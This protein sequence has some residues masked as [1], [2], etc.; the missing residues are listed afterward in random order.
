MSNSVFAI[1]SDGKTMDPSY[2]LLSLDVVKEVNRIPYAQLVL[3]DGDPAQR[4]YEISNT[5]FFEPGKTVEIRL[6]Y[7]G[8]PPKA[9]ATVFK[10]LI[11]G[12]AV[13]AG[14]AGGLLTIELKDVAVKLA[15]VRRSTV[16]RQQSDAEIIGAIL[17]RNGLQEGRIPTTKAKHP[18][19]VQYHCTDWDF[20]LMRAESCGLLVY[21]E[22]GVVSLAQ[23]A[24]TGE[25]AHKFE[26]GMGQLFDF[27][28]EVDAAHQY[29]AVQSVAWDGRKL[30]AS[31]PKKAAPFKPAQGNLDGENIAGKIGD[32][33][34]TLASPVPLPPDEL[35]SWADATLARTR[36]ALIR[37]RLGMPGTSEVK[38]LDVIG[39]DGV[40]RRFDGKT[41]VT[42]IRHR[43]DR[44]GWRTDIQFGLAPERYAARPE[45]MDAPA[46]GLL[47][48]VS[49]L[50]VG[51][52]YG[53]K[54]DPAKELRVLVSLPGLDQREPTVWARLATP[55][56]GKDRG[57][58]FRPEAG[59]EVV[60]GFFNDDPR[61][62]VILGMLY[63]STN[64]PPATVG[65]LSKENIDKGI[66]TKKGT[67][68][69]FVDDTKAKLLIET[70]AANRIV[71]DDDAETIQ[72]ADQHGNSIKL[73]KDG[74]E[75]KSAKDVKIEGRGN[76]EI[77]GQKVD[78]K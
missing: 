39:V 27:E 56:A 61:Q 65:K 41:L 30:E 68:I 55:D 59:D 18:E 29:A 3:V 1:L 57:F 24:V 14:S 6:F 22:N 50:Q 33:A 63:S 73:S 31:Q 62:A 52:V 35:Q 10:G 53:Y 77:K 67:S 32:G 21:V 26:H 12:H 13:Q 37:G 54:E 7:E 51:V 34:Y 38:L 47:P 72:V 36:M 60:V 69:R 78:V 70:P 17:Q 28:I 4:K 74:I 9:N 8:T 64:K 5:P 46:A 43:L 48:A 71:L 76:V 20:M 19:L 49:G 42:G 15:R 25:P 40:G 75:I 45:L 66:V 16:Y 58:F 23:I 2:D 11:V 44:E